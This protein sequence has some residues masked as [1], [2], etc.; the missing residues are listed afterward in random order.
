MSYHD[1][2]IIVIVDIVETISYFFSL[3]HVWDREVISDGCS[4]DIILRWQ[5]PWWRFWPTFSVF[6]L[7]FW[8]LGGQSC[9]NVFWTFDFSLLFLNRSLTQESYTLTE[10]SVNGR[11]PYHRKVP[12]DKNIT[13]LV[14]IIV[15]LFL[16][17]FTF[18]C[19]CS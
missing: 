17:F 1:D 15:S 9:P 8:F 10:V 13:L 12:D 5:S 11:V 4:V 14:I 6:L 2:I 3:F 7:L 18:N 19:G 16:F